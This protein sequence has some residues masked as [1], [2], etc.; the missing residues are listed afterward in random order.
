MVGGGIFTARERTAHGRGDAARR[1]LDKSGRSQLHARGEV[2]TLEDGRRIGYQ[3]LILLRASFG[4]GGGALR[5]LENGVTS[6]Y[7]FDWRLT[8]GNWCNSCSGAPRSSHAAAHAHQLLRR[9]RRNLV[10][11][12][13][14]VLGRAQGYQRG[15]PHCRTA[16]GS[17][18]MVRRAR[19][20]QAYAI[21]RHQTRTQI[22][23][24]CHRPGHTASAPA[25]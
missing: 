16:V 10:L 22:E 13:L 6:H 11:R 9:S 24:R 23:G 15:I 12:R 14:A 4:R 1:E 3:V 18:I 20:V 5:D 25:Q 21:D 8:H 2:V 17:R 19:H 7:R